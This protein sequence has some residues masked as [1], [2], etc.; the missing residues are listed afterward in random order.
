MRFFKKLILHPI[1]SLLA[2]QKPL[3]YNSGVL[4]K[5]STYTASAYIFCYSLEGSR[6]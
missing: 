2:G 4:K 3:A 1:F 5:L 6:N